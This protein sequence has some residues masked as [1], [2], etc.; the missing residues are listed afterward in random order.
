MS[1][2]SLAT[3]TCIERYALEAIIGQGG[4]ATVYSAR[5][6]VLG[7]FH[8]VKVVNKASRGWNSRILR[9][10]RAQAQ[11]RHP[12]IV[13]VTDV[14]THDD[15][16]VLV[17]EY[18]GGP[19]LHRLVSSLPLTLHQ[20]DAIAQGV[21][22]GV[23]AAHGWGFV[24]RDL[25]PQNILCEVHGEIVVPK[26]TDF[27]LVRDHDGE[28]LEP[29]TTKSGQLM[30]TPGYMAPE[31]VENARD[32]DQRADI[33]AL[34]AI[35]YY[36]VT[37]VEPFITEDDR[38]KLRALMRGEVTPPSELRRDIPEEW[39]RAILRALEPDPDRRT[40]D[41]STLRRQWSLGRAH[42]PKA[43]F[44]LW[45]EEALRRSSS[46]GPGVVAPRR[47]PTIEDTPAVDAAMAGLYGEEPATE[48]LDPDAVGFEDPT[49]DD[50]VQPAEFTAVPALG[51]S[52]PLDEGSRGRPSPRREASE[53]TYDWPADFE[54]GLSLAP[55]ARAQEASGGRSERTTE[56]DP[57]RPR[58]GATLGL[59]GLAAA[60]ALGVCAVGVAMFG[61]DGS[62]TSAA[63]EEPSLAL[64]AD[65]EPGLDGVEEVVGEALPS[66][67]E[68]VG[69]E[70]VEE[71]A[72]PVATSRGSSGSSGSRG[73]SS[74][75]RGD[76]RTESGT[77]SARQP[78]A[79]PSSAGTGSASGSSGSSGTASSGS[80]ASV[81]QAQPR[82]SLQVSGAPRA[83]LTD[84]AGKQ[85]SPGG[86]PPGTYTV[87]VFFDDLKATRVM[88]V[89]LAEGE[90][91]SLSCN[92]GMMVCQ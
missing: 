54:R 28:L 50:I 14:L 58:R 64:G 6:T 67:G 65:A 39:E 33:F 19:P 16:P 70:D 82:S 17:L 80:G 84:E 40:P 3:G 81:G 79:A 25:K 9:E 20:V 30:G 91:R 53:G 29:R 42:L 88:K 75:S 55:P 49:Q 52:L 92:S 32:V 86:V 66:E 5:H 7:S 44:P 12:N 48:Q 8:A 73:A 87:W 43:S 77:G 10:G 63:S 90:S 18:V 51:D 59:L 76:E 46:L 4:M 62:M 69:G 71:A 45:P 1:P 74:S 72:P 37:G 57:D 24:H 83:Y 27:G 60:L 31:Q 35:L 26:I 56:H 47:T 68:G 11:L 38:V 13:A 78:E 41:V 34:G 36:V 61:L 23:E 22:A 21:L 89:D 85:W 2:N 15:K